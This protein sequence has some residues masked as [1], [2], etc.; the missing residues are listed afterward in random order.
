MSVL[1]KINAFLNALTELSK[2]FVI[3]YYS[4]ISERNNLVL[5]DFA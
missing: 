2:K 4:E 3:M 1:K 5:V